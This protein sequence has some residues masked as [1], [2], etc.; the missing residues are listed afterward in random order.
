MQWGKRLGRDK[1]THL[2]CK[3]HSGLVKYPLHDN[4]EKLVYILERNFFDCIH[5]VDFFF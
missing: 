2:L 3:L 5:V 4:I 1:I